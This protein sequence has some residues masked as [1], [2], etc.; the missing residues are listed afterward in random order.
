MCSSPCS[1]PKLNRLPDVTRLASG[2]WSPKAAVRPRSPGLPQERPPQGSLAAPAEREVHT[3]LLAVACSCQAKWTAAPA[4]AHQGCCDK[5]PQAERF[6]HTCVVSQ[7]WRPEAR[8]Q[9]VGKVGCPRGCNGEAVRGL[10]AGSQGFHPATFA[11]PWLVEGSP[12]PAFSRVS[13]AR[14]AFGKSA[15]HVGLGSILMTSF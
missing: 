9:G 15:S 14:F 6:K 4:R 3:D 7:L 11:A 10:R 8:N 5:A 13:V 2:T 12:I 1:S